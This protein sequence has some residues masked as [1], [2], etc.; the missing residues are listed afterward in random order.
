MPGE[1]D[2]GIA[3]VEAN[4]SGRPVIAFAAGGA[5]DSQ[6]D[7][8]TGVFFEK[9]TVESLIDAMQR[10][11][12]IDFDPQEIRRHAETFDTECFKR[13]ILRV[14]DK[15]MRAKA[16]EKTVPSHKKGASQLHSTVAME[17]LNGSAPSNGKHRKFVS[18]D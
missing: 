3:P 2:F 6:I 12:A 9:P 1:E 8:V 7:G 18:H 5:L 10:A 11:D 14:I 16:G 4:A 17:P 15:V 13:E